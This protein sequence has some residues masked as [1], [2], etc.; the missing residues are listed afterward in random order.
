VERRQAEKAVEAVERA[1]TE[2]K[3]E[4]EAAAVVAMVEE[5][6]AV[7]RGTR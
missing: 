4:G 6:V 2:A 3:G 1:A 5:T 7:E